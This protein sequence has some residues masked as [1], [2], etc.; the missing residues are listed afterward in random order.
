MMTY[1][2]SEDGLYIGRVVRAG[3][4]EGGA[5][6]VSIEPLYEADENGAWIEPIRNAVTRFPTRGLVFWHRADPDAQVDTIWEFSV[7][8]H[9]SASARGDFEAFHVLEAVPA[10]EVIDFREWGEDRVR[11]ELTTV[12]IRRREAPLRSVLLW[13]DA[14]QWIGPVR[15]KA[16]AGDRWELAEQT[17]SALQVHRPPKNGVS[18]VILNGHRRLLLNSTD[19]D[20]G[21]PIGCVNWSSETEFMLDVLKDLRRVD[22]NVA[23]K[24]GITRDI[25]KSYIASLKSAGVLK[26]NDDSAR[27]RLARAASIVAVLDDNEQLAKSASEILL[28]S[29]A[30][31]RQLESDLAET[32]ERLRVEQ[33]EALDA[34]VKQQRDEL[35]KMRVLVAEKGEQ[36]VEMERKVR[37]R[38]ATLETDLAEYRGALEGRL[39]EIAATPHRS[40]AELSVISSA[41]GLSPARPTYQPHLVYGKCAP[42]AV[43]SISSKDELHGRLIARMMRCSIPHTTAV[44]L[45]IAWMAGMLPLASGATAEAIVREC[46][47]IVAGGEALWIPVAASTTEPH[48]LFGRYDSTRNI[49]LPHPAG[50]LDAMLEAERRE[51]LSIA[52]FEGVNRAPIESYLM[53]AIR[54]FRSDVPG[55]NQTGIP[56][57]PQAFVDANDPYL[58]HSRVSWHPALLPVGLVVRGISALPLSSE[59]WQHAVLVD[60]DRGLNAH[61]VGRSP[62]SDAN[63]GGDISALGQSVWNGL[64]TTVRRADG[65]GITALLQRLADKAP[66]LAIYREPL[67]RV[68]RASIVMGD[69]PEEAAMR[70]ARLVVVPAL[71]TRLELAERLGDV[72][73][74]HDGHWRQTLQ[75]A[76]ALS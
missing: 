32:K 41:L 8:A 56:L 49:L 52:V 55:H 73:F 53:P 46:A 14:D 34:E 51:H 68:Y 29:D 21:L 23:E 27:A 70:A 3:A 60:A 18:Q 2:N 54:G 7:K 22:A 74:G 63:D 66:D 13:V 10:V 71:S 72:V 1:M 62:E 59:I 57:V 69:G 40:F 6:V 9:N 50:L 19:Q 76:I 48:E 30:V 45:L 31:R 58:A 39:R 61:E 4:S 65:S 47:H 75:L 37:D 15:L 42:E 35:D 11:Q 25:L 36:L 5:S 38:A 26:S 64:R 20:V 17:R 12:G 24:L 43:A 33:R 28:S 16:L 44:D 67:A